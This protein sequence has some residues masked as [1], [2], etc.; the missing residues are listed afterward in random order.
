M[1]MTTTMT[2]PIGEVE[3]ILRSNGLYTDVIGLIQSYLVYPKE[4]YQKMFCKVIE[5]NQKLGFNNYWA[6]NTLNYYKTPLHMK[7]FD[8][9]ETKILKQDWTYESLDVNDDMGRVMGVKGII[10]KM[11]DCWMTKWRYMFIAN[12]IRKH[13]LGVDLESAYIPQL[14]NLMVKYRVNS[15]VLKLFIT[16]WEK[17]T[18]KYVNARIRF[19][20]E[21]FDKKYFAGAYIGDI[22]TQHNKYSLNQQI[23]N[24]MFHHSRQLLL[25]KC[26]NNSGDFSGLFKYFQN[27][28]FDLLFVERKENK[29]HLRYRDRIGKIRTMR[30]DIIRYE[31]SARNLNALVK[32]E[33]IKIKY[34]NCSMDKLNLNI[35]YSLLFNTTNW[36]CGE[37]LAYFSDRC[38]EKVYSDFE[39]GIANVKLMIECDRLR[40]DGGMRVIEQFTRDSV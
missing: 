31:W 17:P 24:A 3:R 38:F 22:K 28:G 9:I 4:H 2:R 27:L 36:D 34:I 21:N 25:E 11:S 23:V 5:D 10:E 8:V 6:E 32:H 20:I 37:D 26:K 13:L 16:N 29:L 14:R 30:R 33:F 15:N 19:D 18:N 1:S 40:V 39:M 7:L 35:N 12:N